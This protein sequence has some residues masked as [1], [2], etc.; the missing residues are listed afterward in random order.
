MMSEFVNDNVG[1]KFAQRDI[2]PCG[3][4]V[5]DRPPEQPNHIRAQG[6][7][8]IGTF[9]DGATFIEASQLEGIGYLKSL[10]LFVGREFS[11][12]NRD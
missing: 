9:G 7:F 3:P 1:D 10:Q 2:A 5:D 6:L 12:L 8:R 4:L 11:D